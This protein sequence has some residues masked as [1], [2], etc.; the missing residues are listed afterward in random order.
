MVK[1]P[2]LYLVRLWSRPLSVLRS[3]AAEVTAM[4]SI[5]AGVVGIGVTGSMRASPL[6]HPPVGA[7]VSGPLDH[8]VFGGG[9]DGTGA[10]AE[11]R[12]MDAKPLPG[13]GCV[14]ISH[15]PLRRFSRR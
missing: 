1:A 5:R 6:H 15:Q 13:S 14:P 9:V 10:G 4:D 12:R 7:P 11:G 3:K 2:L 8:V